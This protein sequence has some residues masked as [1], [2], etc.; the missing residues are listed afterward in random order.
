M[1]VTITPLLRYYEREEDLLTQCDASKGGLGAALFQD[2]RPLAYESRSL[3]AAERNYAQIEKKVSAI[4]FVTERFHHYTYGR[5]I[6][7]G[8]ETSC[9][10]QTW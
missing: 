3:S 10:L 5:S 1:M 9:I 2:G 4:V 6:T 7:E 8:E